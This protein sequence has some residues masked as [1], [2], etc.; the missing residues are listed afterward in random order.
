M[1]HQISEP[2]SLLWKQLQVCLVIPKYKE[3]RG[4]NPLWL[5]M[6]ACTQRWVISLENCARVKPNRSIRYASAKITFD[7]MIKFLP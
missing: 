5:F 6:E 1:R 7:V 3:C 2:M 4:S